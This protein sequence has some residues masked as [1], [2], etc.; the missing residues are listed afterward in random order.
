M[1]AATLALGQ[2]CYTPLE[3]QP[4]LGS[5]WLRDVNNNNV[6][7][8]ID[9]APPDTVMRLLLALND[10][11]SSTDLSRFGSYGT[12]HYRG[13]YLSF[14]VLDNVTRANAIALGA[15]PRVSMVFLNER[16][17]AHLDTS[18]AAIRVGASSDYSPNTI[19][20]AAPWLDGSGI[21]IAMLDTGADDQMHADLMGA[22]VGGYDFVANAAVNPH[23]V[24]GHGTHTSSIALGRGAQYRGIAPGAALVDMKVL[25]DSGYG[26]AEW[27][28]QALEMCID[29]RRAGQNIRV[30][31]MSLGG[32]L[33]SNGFDI[34]SEVVN[35]AVDAGMVVVSSAG[36]AGLENGKISWPAAA[37]EGIAVGASMDMATIGRG[38]DVIA[39]FSTRGPRVDD[40][41]SLEGHRKPDLV[42]P[43]T[44]RMPLT[45]NPED[46]PGCGIKAA[47]ANTVFGYV[48]HPGTSMAAPHVA[49]LAALLSQYSP[50]LSARAIKALLNGTAEDKGAAGWDSSYGWG[51]VDGYAALNALALNVADVGFTRYVGDNGN[52]P[53]W[54]SPD[55]TPGN[56][57][58]VAGVP[59]SIHVRVWNLTGP[60][61][62]KNVTVR[63]GVYRYG[64]DMTMYQLGKV[65]ITSLDPGLDTLIVL[66]WTPQASGSGVVHECL[67][68]EVIYPPDLFPPANNFAQHNVDVQVV[69]GAGAASATG[70][71]SR[72]AATSSAL[73]YTL[74]MVN[75]TQE[76][77]SMDIHATGG[78]LTGSGWTMSPTGYGFALS[79][80]DCGRAVTFTLTP[81]VGARDSVRVALS[82]TGFPLSGSGGYAELGGVTI[83]GRLTPVTGVAGPRE[84]AAF[85]AVAAPNPFTHGTA[86]RLTLP[87]AATADVAIFDLA[88]RRLRVLFTGPLGAGAHDLRWDGR[89]NAG[90]QVRQGM[91][92]L[93]IRAEGRVIERKLFRVD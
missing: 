36:N 77:M 78:D 72:A 52:P 34:V 29:W 31:N 62:A 15:D 57:Q 1:I 12:V 87:S 40:G 22:Y 13:K 32:L 55:V 21:A 90:A 91:Y 8:A 33:P 3:W 81:G 44:N 82:V 89:D 20:D 37:T 80:N 84:D 88:G 51:E 66:P 69:P 75:P 48:R 23:D 50:N 18:R 65:T 35:R 92:L 45:P 6:D 74:E 17:Q 61:P 71:A 7:D 67:K 39:P 43:G 93:R 79:P 19:A 10:C 85:E 27:T 9:A 38:D 64:N 2:T 28:A 63:I 26:T 25:D 14:V 83:V 46:D 24:D 30:V 73:T 42:A 56:P 70:S 60:A 54:E 11:P 58:I 16:S 76:A 49:G 41:T 47:L 59:N 5:K 53:W 86:L 68:A 4:K